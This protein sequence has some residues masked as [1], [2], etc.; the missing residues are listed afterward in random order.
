V[1]IGIAYSEATGYEG[2]VIGPLPEG[3][4][5]LS[6]ALPW[7]SIGE[8]LLPGLV[9][10]IVGFAEPSS[11]ARTF[12]ALERKPWNANREF[13]SQG[14]ANLASGFSGGFPVGGSFS[15]SALN[16]LAG[17]RTRIAGAVTGVAVLAFLPVASVLS[18][19]PTAVLAAI[20]IG[21]VSRLVRLSPLARLWRYSWPQFAIAT[22]TFA[23]TLALAPHVELAVLAGIGLSVAVHLLRELSLDVDSRMEGTALHLTP[24]GVLWFGNA[25]ILEDAFLRALADHVAARHLVVHLDGLGRIDLSGALALR[26]LLADARAAGLETAVADVPPRA[27]RVVSRVVLKET[28]PLGGH[29]A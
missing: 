7:E 17:A 2:P 20:V 5:P 10:A 15:R 23:L 24:R 25:R 16:R 1:G 11:I 4:P 8:V 27:R 3:L 13:V 28:D 29:E 12:A 22:T 14:A 26:T 9:I 6:L 19:L 21:A 18:P